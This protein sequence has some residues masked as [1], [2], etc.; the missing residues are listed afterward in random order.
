MFRTAVILTIKNEIET[1]HNGISLIRNE[2]EMINI[3]IIFLEERKGRIDYARL[4]KE[5][6]SSVGPVAPKKMQMVLIAGFVSGFMF[7]FL[8]FFLTYI[9]ESKKKQRLRREEP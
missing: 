6:T 7:L 5:P 1:V 3:D 9:E 2:I 4:V 8:A